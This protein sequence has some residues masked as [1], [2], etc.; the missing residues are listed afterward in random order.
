MELL[1]P[2][3]GLLFWTISMLIILLPLIALFS[4]LK[5]TFKDNTTKL[6]W[7]LVFLLVP[8]AGSILY[9]AIGRGQRVKIA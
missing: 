6:M 2:E 4:L 5:L 1:L 9:F 7:V 8:V 3:M